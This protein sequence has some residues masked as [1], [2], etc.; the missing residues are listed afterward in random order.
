MA[1]VTKQDPV[2]AATFSKIAQ[3]AEKLKQKRSK[4]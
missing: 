2:Y 3:A 1:K 4:R